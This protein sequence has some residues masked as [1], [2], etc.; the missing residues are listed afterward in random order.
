MK[1]ILAVLMMLSLGVF[2][3]D[4][5]VG[6]K[7][8]LVNY[9]LGSNWK[10][11]ES[12]ILLTVEYTKVKGLNPG[13]FVGPTVG[14]EDGENISTIVTGPHI[15][16]FDKAGVGFGMRVWDAQRSG[17]LINFDDNRLLVTWRLF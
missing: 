17:G 13:W 12:P 4:F 1:Y 2:A 15:T 11:L 5:Q 9:D 7:L 6:G 10:A 16:L 8:G 14:N 3:G